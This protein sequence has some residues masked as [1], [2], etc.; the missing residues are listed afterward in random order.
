MIR[1]KFT[2]VY[3]GTRGL[4][5]FGAYN[6]ILGPL[7]LLSG[8]GINMSGVREI[9]K[10]AG[11]N[12]QEAVARSLLVVRRSAWVTGS[13]GAL[14]MLAL[15]YPLSVATFGNAHQ[16]LPLCAL[17]LTILIGSVAGGLGAIIQGLR[18]IRDLATQAILGSILS[19]PIVIPMMVLWGVKALVPMMLT[20]SL[21]GFVVT[22]R[23]ARRIKVVP[24]SM[25]WRE[26]WTE[27]KPMLQLGAVF[28]GAY[29][30]GSVTSYVQRV[31]IIR[32]L[33]LGAN[34]I[35]SAAFNL[36]NYYVGFILSAMA[37]DF[38]PRLTEVNH[39]QSE[40]NRLVNEQ[41]EVG[42]LL[43]L[44]GIIAT[45]TLAP[46]VISLFYTSEFMPAVA[47]LRWQTLGLILR[48]ISWPMGF[49]MQA[50]GEKRWFFLTETAANVASVA[51]LWLG[52]RLF[53]LA[54]TGMA[55]F[56]LY[57]FYAILMLFVSKRLTGFRW[58]TSNH[59]LLVLTVILL[60]TNM[61]AAC[62]L[63]LLQSALIGVTCAG[64]TAC[65]SLRAITRLTGTNPLRLA[66]SKLRQALPI[67][68][69]CV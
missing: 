32:Q 20:S 38:Y 36:S 8:M 15:S 44:P 33:G 7:A 24:V 45:L 5:L 22:W 58:G 40:V 26:T 1:V 23:F 3:L 49:I 43:A 68:A 67:R 29:L 53:G 54:G 57:A 11:E 16:T 12:D 50:K 41:T 63:P 48:L 55:F 69:A 37:T 17:S 2:A 31:I 25:S 65:F 60:T 64:L 28:V 4:G 35:Y 66:L 27:A 51:F 52:I 30:I 61:M 46:L 6:T 10:A 13:L 21:I 34:G 9:A 14:L 42:L 39:D 47:V 59:K 56:A 62:W 19:L 18:R